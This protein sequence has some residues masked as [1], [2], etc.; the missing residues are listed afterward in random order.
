MK[1]LLIILFCLCGYC[2]SAQTKFVYGFNSG[3]GFTEGK[4]LDVNNI[5]GLNT[6]KGAFVK[7]NLE[8]DWKVNKKLRIGGLF[9]LDAYKN[10]YQLDEFEYIYYNHPDLYRSLTNVGRTIRNTGA[11][12]NFSLAANF[13]YEI[14][15]NKRLVILPHIT[16]KINLV[17]LNRDSTANGLTAGS[18]YAPDFAFQFKFSN[19]HWFNPSFILGSRLR[20]KISKKHLFQ[21]GIGGEFLT[22]YLNRGYVR[23]NYL[24]KDNR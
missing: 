10:I 24:G 16:T 3:V 11:P 18:P 2:L 8:T 23:V 22:K 13:S 20:Y 7:F 6:I 5:A 1:K 14:N 17:A 9:G 4:F 15:V 19:N 12:S 21:F